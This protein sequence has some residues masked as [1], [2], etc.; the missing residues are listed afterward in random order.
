MPLPGGN[1]PARFDVVRDDAADGPRRA[2]RR[3][4]RPRPARGVSGP[5]RI[6]I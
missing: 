3:G 6:E 2:S 4:A 1:G 5:P